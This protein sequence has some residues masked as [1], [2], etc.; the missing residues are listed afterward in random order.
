MEVTEYKQ[1]L[2]TSQLINSYQ[3]RMVS[4][5]SSL[6]Y[7][8]YGAVALAG[9][10]LYFH[11]ECTREREDHLRG[12]ISAVYSPDQTD[13]TAELPFTKQGTQITEMAIGNSQPWQ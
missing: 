1:A 12:K 13:C 11:L 7:L 5:K 8:L 2:I 10:L 4:F 3:W 6:K 9:V